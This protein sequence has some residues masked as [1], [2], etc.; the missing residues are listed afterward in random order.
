[1]YSMNIPRKK[2]ENVVAIISEILA[3][4]KGNQTNFE[5]NDF[6]VFELKMIK[7]ELEEMLNNQQLEYAKWLNRTVIS[8]S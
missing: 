4:A 1:A 6:E 8:S 3:S 2:I 5:L 7:D